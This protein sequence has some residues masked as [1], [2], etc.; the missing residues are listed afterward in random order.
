MLINSVKAH[1]FFNLYKDTKPVFFLQKP[2]TI[3]PVT[4]TIHKK[5]DT[6]RAADDEEDIDNKVDY[7]AD[8]SIKIEAA[9]KKVFLYG[10]ASVHYQD[11]D[12]KAD[13]IE[14]DNN[15]NLITAVGVP[16]SNGIPKGSPEFNQGTDKMRSEKIVYNFKTKKGKIYGILTKQNEFF[17]FGE[18]VKKDSSNIMYIKRMKCIPCEFEDAKIYF[19]ASKAKIIPDDKIVTGPV[20]LEVSNIPTPLGLPFGFFPNVKK[21]KS[22]TGILLPSYGYSASQG[23]YLQNF[24]FFIPINNKVHVTL[25]ANGYSNGSWA[26]NP[27]TDY[28]INYKYSGNFTFNYSQTRLGIPEDK[29]LLHNPDGTI[30][31]DPNLSQ[32]LQN[33]KITWNH[34]QDNRFN[35]T[36]RFS[37]LVNAG[38]A[39]FG[40]YN[41]QSSVNY[42]QSNLSSNI[43]YTKMYKNST[44]TINVRHAQDVPTHFVEIDAPQLTYSL[45]RQFPFKNNA[46]TTQTWLDKLYIDYTLQT[47]ATIKTQDTLLFKKGSLS[48]V[49]DGLYQR[50]PIG[51]N[52][53]L[54][55]YFTLSPQANFQQFTNLQTAEE[56]YNPATKKINTF[57]RRNPALAFDQ[58]YQIN[59]TTKVYGDYLFKS[60]LIKQIR[61]Q[62]IPTVGFVYHPDMQNGNLGF[63]KQVTD[64]N[65]ITSYYSRFQNG[66]FGGPAGAES[67]A[68]TF[69]I[70][71]TLDAKIRQKT[72]TSISYRKVALLQMLSIG[73]SYDVA[74]KHNKLSVFNLSARTALFKNVVNLNFVSSFDPYQVNAQGNRDT[75]YEFTNHQ[76]LVRF[77]NCN[78]SVNGTL[79]NTQFKALKDSKQPF[80]IG[81]TYNLAFTPKVTPAAVAANFENVNTTTA[82]IAAATAQAIKDQFTQNLTAIFSFKPTPLWKFDVRTGYDFKN[83]N[84]TYTSFTIYRDLHC[85]EAHIT[86]V[87]FGFSKQYMLTLNL[88]VSSLRDMK[89][90]KQKLWQ[91]NL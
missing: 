4:N 16:D 31:N 24:G 38:T 37:A 43:A 19:R 90:P 5:T 13:Y 44:L 69:N 51:T 21:E 62:I 45:N 46:H 39:G 15:T 56:V 9:N 64:S 1:A 30:I 89:I 11:F 86:W 42:L 78:F 74:A 57:V 59:V 27:T 32:K 84:I 68:I 18:Q 29:I 10:N 41:N 7:D 47:Q 33:F 70:N 66:L 58:S 81:L 14:I 55:K 61:H 85:W 88:K 91:D 73:G 8:D 67:G 87:P 34:T 72:D 26:F 83:A 54:L 65:R 75:I 25:F 63:Y 28:K 35:P 2:D 82:G 80:S 53:N 79:T 23:F 49:R 36:I 48:N 71:N 50:I 77:T 3:K 60:K 17:I 52:I 6:L 12:L 76:K 22:K 40:K 20:F